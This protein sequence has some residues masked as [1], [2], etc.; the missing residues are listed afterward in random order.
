MSKLEKQVE[1]LRGGSNGTKYED[2][3][4][5]TKNELANLKVKIKNKG[6]ELLQI[7]S[8]TGSI[9]INEYFL[10]EEKNIDGVE[11]KLRAKMI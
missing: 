4:R 11:R 7:S 3:L 10:Y 5:R 9:K 1:K 2:D 8:R 6:E